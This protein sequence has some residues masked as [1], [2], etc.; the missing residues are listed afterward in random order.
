MKPNI[1][2]KR[3]QNSEEQW[4]VVK[5]ILIYTLCTFFDWLLIVPVLIQEHIWEILVIL[6]KGRVGK[7]KEEKVAKGVVKQ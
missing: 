2:E 1:A 4:L 3:N 5:S 7:K 6:F